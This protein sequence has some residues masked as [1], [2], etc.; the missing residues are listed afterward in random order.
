LLLLEA[1][2]YITEHAMGHPRHGFT[3]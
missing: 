2:D 3:T 1:H